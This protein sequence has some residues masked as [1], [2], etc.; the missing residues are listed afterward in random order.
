MSTPTM[1]DASRIAAGLRSDCPP[2]GYPTD[3][4]RCADCPRRGGWHPHNGGPMPVDGNTIVRV[5]LRDGHE[6]GLVAARVWANQWR[7]RNSDYDIIAYRVET[8]ND[9]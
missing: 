7:H 6:S 5:R 9:H 4:T 1:P 8:P 3:N 2:D